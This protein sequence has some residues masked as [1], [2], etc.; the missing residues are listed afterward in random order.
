ML[1]S[2]ANSC[3]SIVNCNKGKTIYDC[4]DMRSTTKNHFVT[5]SVMFVR[6]LSCS[7]GIPYVCSCTLEFND[8]S[9]VFVLC[10]AI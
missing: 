1:E 6:D 8:G 2:G 4:A 9:F 7:L 10:M 5:R 3:V